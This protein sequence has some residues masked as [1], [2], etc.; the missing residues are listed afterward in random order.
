MVVLFQ[1]ARVKKRPKIFF[2]IFSFCKHLDLL[3][4]VYK[5]CPFFKD[6]FLHCYHLVQL[7]TSWVC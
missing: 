1:C 7:R 3:N 6:Y 5:I 2:L 4:L